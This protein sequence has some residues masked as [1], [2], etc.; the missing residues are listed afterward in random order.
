MP[1]RRTALLAA[2]A[3]VAAF[4]F[5]GTRGLYDPSEGRYAEVAREM[6]ESGNYLD[7]T[8][9]YRPHWTKPPLTYW[10][11]A[12]GLAVCGDNTWGVRSYN[13]VAFVLTTL[14]VAGIGATLWNAEAGF[15]AGLVFLSS[16]YP[17]AAAN[18]TTADTLLATWTT[19]A[20]L[21][22]V[23]AWKGARS[24]WWVR[25]MWLMFGVAFSTKG[26]PALLPLLALVVFH[27]VARR[28]FRMLDAA[29]MILFV[30]AGFWW[31]ALESL[32]HPGLASYFVGKEVIAR[33]A[34]DEFDRNGEWYGAVAVYLPVLL[35]APGAWIVE[36]FRVVRRFRL[37]SVRG[38][39]E[40]VRLR[41]STRSFLL[42][43]LLLPL[44]A[45]S[46][47]RSRLPLY[48][49]PLYPGIALAVARG[50]SASDAPR[51]GHA[52]RVAAA[53]LVV[54]VAA[55]GIFAFRHSDRD[56]THM[57]R[58]VVDVTGTDARLRLF[59]ESRMYGFQFY[60]G[61]DLQRVTVSGRE[62]WAD[63]SLDEA[64][65]AREP[66]RPLAFAAHPAFDD[67]LE[68]ALISRGIRFRETRVN[69]WDVFLIPAP[70]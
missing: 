5:Q 43:W 12:G 20:M 41:A 10:A 55:K 7:P 17:F 54:L 34:T 60:A 50:I 40:A 52:L 58:C 24:A 62:S 48:L 69:D 37:F 32:R 15:L 23:R 19:L 68:A 22:Y 51:R 47:S 64:L 67:Q 27:A 44:V 63:A 28:P 36:V 2:I 61:K 30:A 21:G 31:Y 4:A 29:G 39:W 6:R 11:I 9:A 46:L 18:A 56:A 45:F 26:P 1:S 38:L 66:G 57:Y 33:N 35:V 3:L 70:E 49:L 16:P 53:S 25:F 59:R 65:A 42:L 8:L 13:A 14:A